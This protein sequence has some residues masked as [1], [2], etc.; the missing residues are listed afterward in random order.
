M[1][2]SK[3]QLLLSAALVLAAVGCSGEEEPGAGAGDGGADDGPGASGDCVPPR[4]FFAERVWAPVMSRTCINC[5][6][7]DGV[8]TANNA[9]LQLLPS[10]YPGFLD[11]NFESASLMAR[12]AF[13]GESVLLQKPL[14]R[15]DHGG[16]VQLEED[17]DEY[18]ALAEFVDLVTAG[19]ECAEPP[20]AASFSDVVM[21]DAEATFRKASLHLAGR[22]PSGEEAARLREE[23]DEALAPLLDALLQER[24]FLD[25]LEDLF[26]DFLLTDLYL[27]YVGFAVN[28]L[29]DDDYPNAGDPY[30]ALDDDIRRKINDALG[31]EPLELI[32]YVVGND[33]PFSEIL[34][35]DYTVVNPFSAIVYGLD[36][37]FAD[38]SDER[39][40]LEAKVRVQRPD[41]RVSIP[42]AG[43]LTTPS[44]LNR[45]PT[46]P[47][48]RNRHRARKI[49][50]LFLATDIL[51]VADR[52]IDPT[53]S[54]RF[55]NP[56]RDDPQCTG[57]HRQIDPIAG[58]FL[59]W[60]ERDQEQY[61]PDQEWHP[62]MF[63][64]GFGKE[65]MDTAE[66]DHA[67]Q[68]LA[69]RIVADPRFVLSTVHTLYRGILGRE[70]LVYPS[71]IDADD[72]AERLAAWQAQDA[73]FTAIGEA[74]VAD[75][76]NLKTAI[77][78][79]VL[80]PY[81]RAAN[82]EADLS[83]ARLVELSDVGT[84]RFT[85]PKLLANKIEA[86]TG[87]RWARGW[88]RSDYL[89]SDY[90]ILYGGID[91]DSVIERLTR[92]NGVMANVAWRMANEVACQSVGWD[93][94]LPQEDRKLF[95][96]VTLE[97]VPEGEDAAER[98]ES[99]QAIRENI[100]YLHERILGERLDLDDPEIDRS[101]QLFEETWR[102]G[103]AKVA[104][105]EVSRSITWRC[106]GR[107]NP[108]NGEELPDEQRVNRDE[109]Y[110][111]RAWLAVVTY[112]LSDYRFLYE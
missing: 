42:H 82:A 108:A 54:G 86:V 12:F 59:R 21:L 14:G 78:E 24:A 9:K 106:Q 36:L 1:W 70:P 48:N 60:D 25:R 90:K 46:T 11:A 44:F 32:A 99:V 95:P 93:F 79:L 55:N 74:F 5:H 62:E 29:G 98:P 81:Y 77:R 102:E 87:Y 40:F 51:L 88:D 31:R 105:E 22:L 112:L 18:A 43:I 72:F 20:V 38:A 66:Y 71:D 4:A 73:V 89:T 3:A 39:E 7:P 111:V 85:I 84:G 6:S 34:T 61:E 10:A 41:G 92:P 27:R 63:P 52:P 83:D 58:A 101:Y 76:L 57:C 56:T 13:D 2:V 69:R 28:L 49:Y 33:R 100:Q 96:H 109:N 23:G 97:D 19:E 16:G 65:V 30:D 110:A 80:S 68:W 107:A 64:P 103:V 37:P 75:D 15:I 104:S 47:T 50:E 35:A 26:N 45:F 67:Q 8:A 94:T 91:S 53:A 17:S